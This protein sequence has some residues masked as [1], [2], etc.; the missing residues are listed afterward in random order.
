MKK[1][2]EGKEEKCS[3]CLAKLSCQYLSRDSGQIKVAILKNLIHLQNITL[4]SN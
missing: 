4:I 2:N 3:A 1:R